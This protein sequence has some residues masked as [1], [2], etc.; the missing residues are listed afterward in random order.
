MMDRRHLEGAA[1][2]RNENNLSI[3]EN[4]NKSDVKEEDDSGRDESF[5]TSRAVASS[6]HLVR[7]QIRFCLSGSR[8][9]VKSEICDRF[10]DEQSSRR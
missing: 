6:P 10:A 3:V 8:R 4:Q 9:E 5:C 1:C 7:E 2:C